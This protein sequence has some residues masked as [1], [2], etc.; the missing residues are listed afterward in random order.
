[1]PKLYHDRI[2]VFLT[3]FSSSTIFFL[4]PANFRQSVL[5]P[6]ASAGL[7]SVVCLWARHISSSEGEEQYL[8][9][10]Q[11]TL[12]LDL[13]ASPHPLMILQLIQA[14]ILLS[15]YHLD[16]GNLFPG[17]H[18]CAAAVSLALCASI[19]SSETIHQ[20]STAPF[21]LPA[22]HI[23]AAT[24]STE[25]V[26]KIKALRTILLLNNF[27]VA[28]SGLPSLISCEL[29]ASWCTVSSY[30]SMNST[31]KYLIHGSC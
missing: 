4:D 7:T 3:R 1:M 15:F 13:S 11:T 28:T 21:A 9:H 22:L 17:R 30:S 27:W 8:A 14:E 23:P 5:N 24:D 26:E 18:H 2:D 25:Y 10:A 19:H 20:T 12:A 31:L 29:S 16:S 6:A